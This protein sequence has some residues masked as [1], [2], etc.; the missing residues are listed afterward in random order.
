MGK[1]ISLRRIS[2]IAGA[3]LSGSQYKFMALASDGQIDPCGA[4]A[5]SVGVLQD[6]PD[7]AGKVASVGIDGVTK[8]ELGATLAAGAEVMSNAAG[9]AV[10]VTSTNR[11]QGILLEGGVDGDIVPM[12]LNL[13]GYASA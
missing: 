5:K 3:D 10:A 11:S 6:N 12:L 2:L 8:I 7:A 4:G 13:N 9:E 1:E